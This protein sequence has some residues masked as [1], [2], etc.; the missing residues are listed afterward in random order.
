MNKL[1]YIVLAVAILGFFSC[2]S[3]DSI[4]EEYIVPNG[5][6]YPGPAKN[7]VAKPGDGRIEIEWQRGADPKVVNARI[8]WNN[9]SDSIEVPIAT[10]MD[11]IS[12]IIGPIPENTYSFMIHTYD[13]KG[14]MSVPTEVTGTV[15]GEAYKRSLTN[16]RIKNRSIAGGTLKLE[17][18]DAGKNETGVNLMQGENE[19]IVVE[20]TETVTEIPDFDMNIPLFYNTMYK[21]DS[22]AIDTFFA[23]TVEIEFE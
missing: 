23:P 20:R 7:A 9:Y 18:N 12:K 3:Q 10:G 2:K 6:S 15:Y 4:Y 16:R 19:P 5:L 1:A 17:W 22:L 14:N 11:I 21:P 8:F 13:A